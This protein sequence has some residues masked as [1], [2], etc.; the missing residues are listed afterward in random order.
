[1]EAARPRGRVLRIVLLWR[2]VARRGEA[3]P[4]AASR[5][6]AWRAPRTGTDLVPRRTQGACFA[7]GPRAW[8]VLANTTER[9]GGAGVIASTLRPAGPFS[10]LYKATGRSCRSQQTGSVCAYWRNGCVHTAK[11]NASNRRI[12]KNASNRRMDLLI[13]LFQLLILQI[14]GGVILRFEGYLPTILSSAFYE[15]LIL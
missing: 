10:P 12:C 2:R 9:R 14:F 1:M 6:G 13:R 11:A 7:A 4:G 8:P 3:W 15:F 5:P